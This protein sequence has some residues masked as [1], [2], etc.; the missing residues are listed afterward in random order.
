MTLFFFIINF[1]ECQIKAMDPPPGKK[2]L[3]QKISHNFRV[4]VDPTA[5]HGMPPEIPGI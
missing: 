3:M 1:S 4:F 5:I 2:I